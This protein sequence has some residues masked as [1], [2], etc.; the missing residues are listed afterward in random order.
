MTSE[1]APRHAH[2]TLVMSTMVLI[3]LI[4]DIM[5]TQGETSIYIRVIQKYVTYTC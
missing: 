2:K 1:L 5:K 3:L 4:H